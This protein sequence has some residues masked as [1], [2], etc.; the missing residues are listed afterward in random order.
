MSLKYIEIKEFKIEKKE[1]DKDYGDISLV[2]LSKNKYIVLV[3][4]LFFE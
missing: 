2:N 1:T 3:E 4:Y